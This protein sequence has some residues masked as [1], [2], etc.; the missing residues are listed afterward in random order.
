MGFIAYKSHGALAKLGRV[1]DV[2][3]WLAPSCEHLVPSLRYCV[4][5]LRSFGVARGSTFMEPGTEGLKLHTSFAS[6]CCHPVC[7]LMWCPPAII[8]PNP[9]G[10]ANHI[11]PLPPI[12]W[13]WSWCLLVT[14]TEIA[15]IQA[16][17]GIG[18]KSFHSITG[19]GSMAM[20]RTPCLTAL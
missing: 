16:E 1:E 2:C 9:S 4:Q 13:C 7:H 14:A 6:C 3:Y 10:A 5:I 18:G 20:L 17:G 11:N 15:G 19:R 12:S 8:D